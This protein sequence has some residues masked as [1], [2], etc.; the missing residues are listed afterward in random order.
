M[1]I[2]SYI[3]WA[4]DYFDL[5]TAVLFC[6][7]SRLCFYAIVIEEMNIFVQTKNDQFLA[8]KTCPWFYFVTQII[9]AFKVNDRNTHIRQLVLY[10]TWWKKIFFACLC[11]RESDNL[12]THHLLKRQ[13]KVV[14]KLSFNCIKTIHHIKGTERWYCI[15]TSKLDLL[16]WDE[17]NE[18][19]TLK[20]A[21]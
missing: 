15:G 7:C 18:N 16:L 17:Y 19:N 8:K 2:I 21:H 14:T 13:F 11:L 6:A 4:I 20:H 3:A 1:S 5:L 10:Y 9:W 12:V